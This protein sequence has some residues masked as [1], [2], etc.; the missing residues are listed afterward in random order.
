[1]QDT[2]KLT[3]KVQGILLDDKMNVIYQHS[4]SNLVVNVGKQWVS[5]LMA[6]PQTLMNAIAVGGSSQTPAVTDTLLYA[7]IARTS[8][9]ISQSNTTITYTAIFL[10]GVGTGTLQEAGIFNS[11]SPNSGVMLARTTFPAVNKT[12]G[13]S[14]SITW[15]ITIN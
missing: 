10:A 5:Q 9:S 4:Q 12:S 2:I 15:Q 3:G 7:E 8:A 14:Y 1:M 6:G 13:N 11:T